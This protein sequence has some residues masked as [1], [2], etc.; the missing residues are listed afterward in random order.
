MPDLNF[1]YAINQWD[2][3]RREAQERAFKVLS[4]GGFKAVELNEGS[5]RWAPLG[6][7]EEIEI[8]FDSV[9]RL[10]DF[11]RSCGI[12]RVYSWFYDPARP[13][14]GGFADLLPLASMPC[15]ASYPFA[16]GPKSVG[17]LGE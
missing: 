11:L 5:A 2:P 1:G 15:P 13:A 16:P 4:L 12:E 3:V 17:K 7:R 6:R 8:N 9:S 10:A 14:V